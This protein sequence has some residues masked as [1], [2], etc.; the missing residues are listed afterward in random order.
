[1]YYSVYIW[2]INSFCSTIKHFSGLLVYILSALMP[3]FKK[4]HKCFLLYHLTEDD[5]VRVLLYILSKQNVY[6]SS[7]RQEFYIIQTHTCHHHV[8]KYPKHAHFTHF[9]LSHNC[10]ERNVKCQHAWLFTAC[11]NLTLS[12]TELLTPLTWAQCSGTPLNYLTY[13]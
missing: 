4:T 2:L 12:I 1:M 5:M 11:W 7:S 10:T 3:L 13:F 8:H 6:R 9:S